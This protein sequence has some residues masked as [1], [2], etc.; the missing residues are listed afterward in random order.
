MY[1]APTISSISQ[2][3]DIDNMVQATTLMQSA[4]AIQICSTCGQVYWKRSH[5]ERLQ[6]FI[7]QVVRPP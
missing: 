3:K 5:V 7:D 6:P 4:E 2:D 1:L